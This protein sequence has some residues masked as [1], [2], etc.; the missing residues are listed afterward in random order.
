MCSACA[1]HVLCMCYVCAMQ[2]LCMCYV[3]AMHVLGMCCGVYVLCMCWACAVSICLKKIFFLTCSR[4]FQSELVMIFISLSASAV[5]SPSIHMYRWRNQDSAEQPQ[6]SH[7]P[8]QSE[9]A[10]RAEQQ[11]LRMIRQIVR[12]EHMHSPIHSQDQSLKGYS[13]NPRCSMASSFMTNS[14]PGPA[15]GSTVDYY[16]QVIHLILTMPASMP[17]LL[18]GKQLLNNLK[19]TS[20]CTF[21]FQNI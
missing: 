15:Q 8:R 9:Q 10:R 7:R 16:H 17:T 11:Y 5:K 13:C 4:D 14:L 2:V 3:C 21:P 6:Q 20:T 1:E 12:R 18:Q 19:T